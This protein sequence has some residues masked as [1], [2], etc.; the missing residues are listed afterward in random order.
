[1]AEDLQVQ[2][3]GSVEEGVIVLTLDYDRELLLKTGFAERLGKVLTERYQE[4]RKKEKTTATS[5]VVDAQSKVAGSPVVRALFDL[6]KEVVEKEGGQVVCINY[7]QDYIPSV[8][9]LGL[10]GLPGFSLADSKQDAF[11]RIKR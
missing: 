2:V 1:M 10:T 3:I 6:W 4:I 8:T 7:P 11:L 5:C 9:S